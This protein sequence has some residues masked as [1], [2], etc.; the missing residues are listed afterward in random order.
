MIC[1]DRN[2]R[3]DKHNFMSDIGRERGEKQSG[4]V[5][6]RDGDRKT[7]ERQRRDRRGEI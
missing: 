5:E 7:E 6:G 2:N 3:D 1:Y 4:N